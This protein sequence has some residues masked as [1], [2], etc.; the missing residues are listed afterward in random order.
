[1]FNT[2]LIII[3]N[4]FANWKTNKNDNS[5]CNETCKLREKYIF[6]WKII[7]K[8]HIHTAPTKKNKGIK[9]GNES[10][11]IKYVISGIGNA[12]WE[13][14]IFLLLYFFCGV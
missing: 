2:F 10:T 11:P 3:F 12:N 4:C 5:K 13:S 7:T 14:V 9:T 6:F 1:M 8:G